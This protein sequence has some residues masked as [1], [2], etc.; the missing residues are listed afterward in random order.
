MPF[1]KC[2]LEKA[3]F[4]KSSAKQLAQNLLFKSHTNFYSNFS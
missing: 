4:K 1:R 2:L 3:T